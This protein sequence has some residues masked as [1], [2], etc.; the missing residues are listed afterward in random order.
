M[1]DKKKGITITT[2]LGHTDSPRAKQLLGDIERYAERH[3]ITHMDKPA[4]GKAVKRILEQF[5]ATDAAR[6]DAGLTVACQECGKDV[7]PG[8]GW[9]EYQGGGVCCHECS[10]A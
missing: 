6:L 3:G 5:F 10:A 7:L 8:S 9:V 1:T 4:L 2:Y